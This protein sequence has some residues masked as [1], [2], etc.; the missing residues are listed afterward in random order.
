M[1]P[2]PKPQPA[3]AKAAAKAQAL[4][5]ADEQY[6]LADVAYVTAMTQLELYKRA[7]KHEAEL[8]KAKAYAAADQHVLPYRVP[9]KCS[10]APP[11]TRDVEKL[12]P[13]ERKS[14]SWIAKPA[15]PPP[16]NDI[17]RRHT[18]ALHGNIVK[19]CHKASLNSVHKFRRLS[20]HLELNALNTQEVLDRVLQVNRTHQIAVDGALEIGADDLADAADPDLP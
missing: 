19:A 18:N 16:Q 4:A 15:V 5:L 1:A 14:I 11:P 17:A 12:P 6:M 10:V 2:K 20:T 13:G 3:P 9:P 8:T 7:A